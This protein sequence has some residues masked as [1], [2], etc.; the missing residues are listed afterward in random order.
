MPP[1][2]NEC[3]EKLVPERKVRDLSLAL[4][5]SLLTEEDF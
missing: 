3:L 1:G 4:S 2:I 5:H